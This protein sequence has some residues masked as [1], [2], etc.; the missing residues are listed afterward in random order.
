MWTFT[1]SGFYSVVK[2]PGCA[3]DDLEVRARCR[4]DLEVLKKSTGVKSKILT[5]F[6]TEYQFR[7][8]MKQQIWAKFLADEAMSIDYPNFK[9]EVLFGKSETPRRRKHRHDVYFE[10]WRAL[11]SLSNAPGKRHRYSRS[12]PEDALEDDQDLIDG[13]GPDSSSGSPETK[14]PGRKPSLRFRRQPS[15]ESSG[16][17]KRQCHHRN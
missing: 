15:R 7:I 10:V 3:P 9:D 4:K 5:N 12:V 13:S 16:S 8:R 17:A 6:G 1:K 14:A 11:L 2:K